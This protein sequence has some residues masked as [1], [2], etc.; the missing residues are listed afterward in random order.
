VNDPLAEIDPAAGIRVEVTD[1]KSS[2]D[3]LYFEDDHGEPVLL[4]RRRQS[5]PSAVEGVQDALEVSEEK[6]RA[7]VRY[8]HP[9]AAAWGEADPSAL[10]A[11]PT[12]P[13]TRDARKQ[14]PRVNEGKPPRHLRILPRWTVTAIAAVAALGAGYGLASQQGVAQTVPDATDGIELADAQPYASAAFKNFA[15]DGE[16]ACT[17]TGPLEAKCIDVDG[18][19]MYSEAS[20]GSD[21]TQFSFTYDGGDNRIGL[22]VFSNQAAAKLWV[23]EDGAQESVHNLVQYG[24][25]ALWGSDTKR[26]REYLALLRDEDEPSGALETRTGGRH[27][28]Q[29][30]QVTAAAAKQARPT[31]QRPKHA[32][33]SSQSN[34]TH[35]ASA[36]GTFVPK[37]THTRRQVQATTPH[38]HGERMTAAAH[39]HTEQA[40]PMPRRLAVLALG[41]LGVDPA[42]PPTLEQ[43]NTL[44]EMGTL[45]A[46]SIVMGVDPAETGVP[47]HEIPALNPN[48]PTE[49]L[50]GPAG[51]EDAQ[52]TAMREGAVLTRPAAPVRGRGPAPGATPPTTSAPTA[53]AEDAKPAGGQTPT[54]PAAPQQPEPPT[55]PEPPPIVPPAAQLPPI[56]TPQPIPETVE[57]QPTTP[58]E[59]P[60]LETP[61]PE[62]EQPADDQ[63]QDVDDGLG[64]GQRPVEDGSAPALV[65]E[66][67]A[68][69]ELLTIPAAW[70]GDQTVQ[71]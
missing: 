57:T 51:P 54:T 55:A 60:V 58:V 11:A 61:A 59:E 8:H 15:T 18:K 44:Q 66:P 13:V 46:L 67:D 32:K 17:P 52:D 35:L 19:V 49:D 1:L 25:Y 64:E 48:D 6:A 10:L 65:G 42:N 14:Q 9:E 41:T 28:G 5:F 63:D 30:E 22:R 43:A 2:A 70:R 56:L 26:L 4:I 29:A 36:T 24:R 38:A 23:Q 53:P 45:V 71:P 37:V 39:T 27:A 31:P 7:I 34:R 62:P 33:S 21:W 68:G 40:T 69:A 12:A 16:M 3:A 50:L 20:V 47:V